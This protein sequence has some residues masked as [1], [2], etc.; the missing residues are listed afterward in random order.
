MED[1][2]STEPF[3]GLHQHDAEA[4]TLHGGAIG[5]HGFV[6]LVSFQIGQDDRAGHSV[7]ERQT[8]QQRHAHAPAPAVPQPPEPGQADAR[9]QQGEEPR[10]PGQPLPDAKAERGQAEP[11]RD[12][13]KGRRYPLAPTIGQ[14]SPPLCQPAAHQDRPGGVQ[15]QQID[16]PFARREAQK[17][18]RHQ[19]P[20]KKKEGVVVPL[21]TNPAPV[22]DDREG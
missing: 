8:E 2:G 9:E 13:Q 14:A 4:A 18:K 7:E 16:R 12:Q 3:A 22:V 15:R 1:A 19:Q 5:E 21:P 6:A 17:Q 11:R 20:E 10:S